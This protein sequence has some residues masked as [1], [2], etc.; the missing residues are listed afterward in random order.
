MT[1]HDSALIAGCCDDG[2]E[3]FYAVDVIYCNGDRCELIRTTDE[4]EARNYH[5]YLVR[6][7]LS[8][9]VD[10]LEWREDV[11]E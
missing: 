11:P 2:P 7:A 6:G 10:R 5:D 9:E 8:P 1:R 4:D 3:T